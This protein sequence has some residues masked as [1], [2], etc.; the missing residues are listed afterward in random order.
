MDNI[1]TLSI[2]LGLVVSLLFSEILGIAAGGMVVP[3]YIALFINHPAT[4]AITMIISLVTYFIVHSLSS[5]IIIYGKRRTVL[6]ILVGF[7]LG[8]L[9]KSVDSIS[10][11]GN[12]IELTVVGYIIPGLIAIWMDRQG[13][14]ETITALITSSIIVRLILILIVGREYAL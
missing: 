1:L 7:M 5:I 12:S 6:M 13:I 14:L 9:V 10:L 2:G 11:G 3:G 8:W 4:I